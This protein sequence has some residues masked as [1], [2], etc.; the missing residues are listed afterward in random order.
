MNG[1][2]TYTLQLQVTVPAVEGQGFPA[3]EAVA[4]EMNDWLRYSVNWDDLGEWQVSE[5]TPADHLLAFARDV[6]G[7]RPDGEGTDDEGEPWV[8]ENDDAVDTLCGLI[9]EARAILG[10]PGDQP[11]RWQ[12]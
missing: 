8:M 6:A 2:R 4:G 5:A 12:S 1:N 3:P 11:E 7:M 10:E 9:G